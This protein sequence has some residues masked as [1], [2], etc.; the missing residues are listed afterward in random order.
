[1]K[2]PQE[3]GLFKSCEV[4]NWINFIIILQMPI[5]I[6]EIVFALAWICIQARLIKR[7]VFN[8]LLLRQGCSICSP[9][10]HVFIVLLYCFIYSYLFPL[11]SNILNSSHCTFMSCRCIVRSFVAIV[12]FEMGWNEFQPA[13]FPS[14]LEILT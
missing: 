12:S 4:L 13:P 1:M 14:Y 8:T 3:Q 11:F 6:R 9:T 2:S 10:I 7:W 5:L